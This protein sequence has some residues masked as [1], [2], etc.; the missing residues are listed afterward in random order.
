MTPS[1]ILK[2]SELSKNIGHGSSTYLDHCM[3]VFAILKEIGAPDEV[4]LAGLYHS[5][6]GSES[7]N[8]H[9]TVSRDTVR[10]LIGNYSEQLVYTFC[11]LTNRDENIL[12]R[13]V[14]CSKE[15][16]DDLFYI[17]YANLK[18]Q[19]NKLNDPILISLLK[20]YEE[21]SSKIEHEIVVDKTLNIFDDVVERNHLDWLNTFCLN[22][23]YTCDHA[24]NRLNFEVDSRFVSGLTKSDFL[25]TNLLDVCKE[26]SKRIG[27][28]LY[29]GNFYINHYTLMT[30]VSRHTD[31]SLPHTYTI[32][33]NCN[34]FWDDDWGGEIKFYNEFS[35]VHKIID[36][37]PGRV[38]FFD[39]R[40]EHKVMPLSSTAKK[41]RFTIAIKCASE[42][43]LANLKLMYGEENLIST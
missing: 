7:F 31:S 21:A 43:G 32:L 37:V 25:A 8:P 42:E 24:S 1:A 36:F 40:I 14:N 18:E 2:F 20:R 15:M 6:Y 9:I 27:M 26:I 5:V 3:N 35:N 10:E 33:I 12:S 16:Y 29:L 4:C 19:A 28:K 13:T 38:I 11:T 34:K 39:S 41:S 30:P 22:S 17:A 23:K